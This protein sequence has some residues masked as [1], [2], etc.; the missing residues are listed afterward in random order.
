MG[1]LV[2][3]LLAVYR[4]HGQKHASHLNKGETQL[5]QKPQLGHGSGGDNVKAVPPAL[6]QGLLLRPGVDGLNALQP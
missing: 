1:G 5:T 2:Q 4:L 6:Y 3:L